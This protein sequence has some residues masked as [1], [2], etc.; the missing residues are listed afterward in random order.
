M[1]IDEIR[2]ANVAAMKAHDQNVRTAYSMVISA[3]QALLTSGSGKEVGDADVIRLIMKFGKE[4]DEE[5]EGYIQANRLEDAAKI[6]KQKEAISVFL[7][8][9]LSEAEIRDIIAKLDDKSIPSI[10]KHFKA[11]YDGKVDMG[12]VNKIARSL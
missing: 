11:N 4:L 7:P 12:L 5:R 6:A 9:M 2:K 10:M 1:L 8:K 3:Y